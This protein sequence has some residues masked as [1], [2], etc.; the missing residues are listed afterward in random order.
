MQAGE[1]RGKGESL[2]LLYLFEHD[3]MGKPQKKKKELFSV[4]TAPCWGGGK[5]GKSITHF[6]E[7]PKKTE[8]KK[9]KLTNSRPDLA[10][11]RK[12]KKKKG[13]EQLAGHLGSPNKKAS[14]AP[15]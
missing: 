13:V 1:G 15:T 7:G 5:R 12:K 4:S 3:S 11:E 6:V 10:A 8:R 14:R 2:V 9:R